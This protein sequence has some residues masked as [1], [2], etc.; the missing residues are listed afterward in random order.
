MSGT[1]KLFQTVIPA[2]FAVLI[3]GGALG[4]CSVTS[5]R[6]TGGDYVDDAALTTSVKSKLA[7]D[8]GVNLATRVHIETFHDIVQLSGFVPTAADK[9]KAGEIALRVE[10]VRGV[11]NNIVIQ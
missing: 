5:G 10:G 4:A 11:R 3:V 8:G 7:A 9:A 1:R 2:A 6:E